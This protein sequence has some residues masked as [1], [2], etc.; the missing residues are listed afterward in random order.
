MLDET[1]PY[2]STFG[3]A[4][5]ALSHPILQRTLERQPLELVVEKYKHHPIERRGKTFTALRK[6]ELTV[7]P[8]A[9]AKGLENVCLGLIRIDH[10]LDKSDGPWL[11][12]D[13][14]LPD[15]T[16]MA[17]FHRLQDVRLDDLLDDPSIPHV[18]DYWQR[19]QSRPSYKTAVTDMHDHEHFRTAI[20]DVFG[21]GKSPH[22]DGARKTLKRLAS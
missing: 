1:A 14:S 16:M 6:G 8:E 9:F 10:Q 5:P 15:I 13:F 2:A 21:T 4:I 11:L 3:M 19:L 12:G 18:G 7:P 20:T 17:C 22:L